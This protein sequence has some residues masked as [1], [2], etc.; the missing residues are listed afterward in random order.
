MDQVA[1]PRRTLR[2][3]AFILTTKTELWSAELRVSYYNVPHHLRGE[4]N[5]MLRV[6]GSEHANQLRQKQMDTSP[7]RRVSLTPVCVVFSTFHDFC[8]VFKVHRLDFA[9][10]K[11]KRSRIGCQMSFETITRW[12][13]VHSKIV[14]NMCPGSVFVFFSS[15][16]VIPIIPRGNHSYRE[17]IYGIYC[18]WCLFY[19]SLKQT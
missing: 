19:P 18:I 15:S 13:S 8:V 10:V 2:F 17:C 4:L 11:S 16:S 9:F 14:H 5:G 3:E 7:T 12:L 1:P 6:E